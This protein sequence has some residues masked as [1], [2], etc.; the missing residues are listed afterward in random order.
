MLLPSVEVL[1]QACDLS[2]SL[3]RFAPRFILD[4]LYPLP[5]ITVHPITYRADRE[6]EVHEILEKIAAE[7]AP[8]EVRLEPPIRVFQGTYLFWEASI[9]DPLRALHEKVVP[10]FE[11]L[12]EGHLL[13]SNQEVLEDPGIREALKESIR[14]TGSP[15]ALKTFLPHIT[16]TRAETA[17]DALQAHDMLNGM[18]PA[19][20][21]A[22]FKADTMWLFEVGNHGM[23]VRPIKEFVFIPKR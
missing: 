15:L 3:S 17:E 2:V 14:A 19:E 6:S 9:T 12:R 5:H 23:C 4:R 10:A 13:P 21:T 16:L 7:T 22:T 20:L 1:G 8:F 11:P 18:D